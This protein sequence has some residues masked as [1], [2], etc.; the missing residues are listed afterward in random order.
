MLLCIIVYSK[1]DGRKEYRYERHTIYNNKASNPNNF[2]KNQKSK[3]INKAIR[4]E[5]GRLL[6][7]SFYLSQTCVTVYIHTRT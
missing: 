1:H 3:Q 6:S 2:L 4:K 7:L 5:V